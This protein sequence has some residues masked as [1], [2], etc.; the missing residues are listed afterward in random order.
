[1]K[2]ESKVAI[3]TGSSGGIGEAYA[4]V[5]HKREQTIFPWDVWENL[6]MYRVSLRF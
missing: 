3:V 1:M 5:W 6:K 2:L 4:Y